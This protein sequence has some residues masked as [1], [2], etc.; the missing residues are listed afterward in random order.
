MLEV[1]G[2]TFDYHY[3]PLLDDV[4]FSLQEGGWLHLRGANGTGKTTLLRLLAGLL[5]PLAGE[6]RFHGRSIHDNLSDYRQSLCYVGHKSGLNP[7][8]TV[9]ENCLFDLCLNGGEGVVD[10]L[11][12][13]FELQAVAQR[14][15]GQL[16][17]GQ[18]RRVALLR[19]AMGKTRLWLLD[20]PLVALD[21]AAQSALI[22]LMTRHVEAGGMIVMTS[23]QALLESPVPVKEYW[24]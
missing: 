7:L 21:A 12:S 20:E 9:R 17:A 3:Q 13:R 24:L 4:C 19:L 8:L 6:V 1:R 16:S 10:D 15:C 2:L 23:H 18:K 14:L 11:L 5:F 22:V